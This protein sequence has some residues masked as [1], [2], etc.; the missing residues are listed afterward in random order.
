MLHRRRH[1]D[2]GAIAEQEA[3]GVDDHGNA[4]LLQLAGILLPQGFD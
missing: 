2:V 3:L 4:S 1:A